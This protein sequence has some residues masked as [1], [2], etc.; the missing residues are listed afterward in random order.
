MKLKTLTSLT[1]AALF[2]ALALPVRLASQAQQQSEKKEHIRYKLIDLGTLGGPNSGNNGESLVMNSE[3]GVAGFADTLDP[4]P[5]CFSDCFAFHAFRWRDGVLTDLGTL[6]GGGISSTNSINSQDQIVGFS[7]NGLI[8]PLAGIPELVATVWQD[9]RIF[10]L[11]TFGGNF[12]L[13]SMNN[14]HQQVVGCASNNIPDSFTPTNVFY[15]LGFDPNQL[16][17]FLWQGKKLRDL[18][19]LGGPD[20]CAVWINDRGQIAGASFTNSNV[21]PETGLPTLDPFLWDDGKML[22]LG[23]LG[24][25]VGL[26]FMVNNRGQLIGISS[27]AEA[28]GACITAPFNG[29]PG[30]HAILWDRGVLTDLGTLGGKFSI[31]NWINDE[32]EIVGVASNQNEQTVFAFVWK[33][34]LMTNLGTLP[35]DCGSEAFAINASGQVV[36]QSIPC[37]GSP[38]RAVL[39]QPGGPALDLNALVNPGSGLLLTDPKIINDAGAIVLEGFLANGDSHSVVLLP[40]DEGEQ[41]CADIAEAPTAV[42]P[43]ISTAISSAPSTSAHA[44]LTPRTNVAAWRARMMGPYRMRGLAATKN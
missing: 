28:P 20:A 21:N 35:G 10:D 14:D 31:A 27:L 42:A 2:A 26:A 33:K 13:A 43:N 37:D 38:N 22:D 23:T 24:G 5:F 8:N 16:R 7:E 36:G 9:G 39:W 11:G 18:G 19:T 40:C 4:D 6:P 12:S 32:G 44:R 1:A 25:T 34:G 17:A 30:C 41:G 3:G 29:T 15:G